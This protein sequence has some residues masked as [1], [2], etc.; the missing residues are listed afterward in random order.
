VSTARS[1]DDPATSLSVLFVEDYALNA[2]LLRDMFRLHAPE[3]R[4][5]HVSTVAAARQRLEVFERALRAP[6]PC[7]PQYDALLTDLDLPDGAGLD[8]LEHVRRRGLALAVV[9][10]TGFDD[11]ELARRAKLAGA[12]A[13]LA[14]DGDYLAR[15]PAILR[16]AV[17]HR[18]AR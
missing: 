6:A 18:R 1:A 12:Y 10:L 13:F 3:I 16:A 5:D 7:A 15:L 8:I 11:A 9:V 4:L 2:M 14:K 17:A